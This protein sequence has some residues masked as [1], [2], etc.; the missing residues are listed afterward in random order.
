VA[1]AWATLLHDIGKATTIR[2][3]PDR[4][5]Y[6]GHAEKSAEIAEKIL[7]RLKFDNATRAKIVWLISKHMLFGDLV[8]MRAA[9]RH[10]YF[11]HPWFP[12][13]VQ[14]CLADIRGTRP[15]D[16]SLYRQVVHQWK[17]ETQMKLLPP[18]KPLLT[19]AEIIQSLHIPKGPQV[20]RLTR[21]LHDA[22]VE[23]LVKSRAEAL[24]FLN[25]CLQR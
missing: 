19:G 3:D 21:I 9:H 4:I 5:R 15:A 22:Q 20:G 14:V 25:K 17:S 10:D 11:T 16:Y 24:E 23:G 8:K 13:L 6:P 12:E 7:H 2:H 1:V 18:P